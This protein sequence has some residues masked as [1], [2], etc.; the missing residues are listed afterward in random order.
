MAS[1]A[2]TVSRSGQYWTAYMVLGAV[3]VAL[4]LLGAILVWL[5]ECHEWAEARWARREPWQ[6]PPPWADLPAV[7]LHLPICNEP[8]K[9]VLDTLESLARL[10]Y[11]ELEVLVV[12]NNTRDEAVWRPVQDACARLGERFRFYHEDQLEGFKAGA[13]NLA[14]THTSPSA[15]VIAVLDADYQVSP[16]WLRRLVPYFR[17]GQV[18][19]VQAPQDYRDGADS[20]FKG[21]CHAE[22]RGFFHIG[23][24]VRDA[25][26]AI[27][28]HGT[29]T[30]LRREALE[31]AG[32]WSPLSITEDAELGLR[33]LAGGGEA[34]YVPESHGRGLTPDNFLDYKGQRFRWALGAVHILREHVG[35]LSG[36]KPCKLSRGQRYHFLAGWLPWLADGASLMLCLSALLWSVMMCVVPHI[37]APPLALVSMVPV[38]LLGAR[39]AKQ[40]HLYRSRIRAT[41]VDTLGGALAGMALMPTVGVAVLLGVAGVRRDFLRTP[42]LACRHSVAGAIRAA[43]WEGSMAS[44]LITFSVVL[45]SIPAPPSDMLA[46][47]TLLLTM[48]LPY[49]CA[50]CVSLSSALPVSRRS[51][52]GDLPVANV[53]QRI[54]DSSGRKY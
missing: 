26:N 51:V 54:P 7:S 2:L 15:A 47:R 5:V 19:I 31:A 29:M 32:G 33:V 34:R 8:P 21:F 11:P 52:Y 44:A 50:V 13:L 14:L 9:L 45:A 38:A 23:M 17:D 35:F 41:W 42:K 53:A 18:D 24:P 46:W 22:Y 3:I 28:T 36:R 10:D 16:H 4:L 30:L 43:R 27:I 48:S 12:D 1:V 20:T 40:V 6:P 37:A 25:R 39:V 49:L